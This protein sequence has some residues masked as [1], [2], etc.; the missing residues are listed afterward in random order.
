MNEIEELKEQLSQAKK[1]LA[2]SIGRNNIFKGNLIAYEEREIA[3]REQLAAKGC[4][5]FAVGSALSLRLA[6]TEALCQKYLDIISDARDIL[7]QRIPPD[8][9][10]E[11]EVFHAAGDALATPSPAAALN[12]AIAAELRRMADEWDEKRPAMMLL[13][14]DLRTRATEL[15]GEQK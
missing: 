8:E 11:W 9:T 1:E 7:F 12:Q 6:D 4:A 13:V 3:L 10:S 2:L 15:E 5:D 14:D